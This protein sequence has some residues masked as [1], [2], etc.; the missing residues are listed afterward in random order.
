MDIKKTEE[1][2]RALYNAHGD[3]A[4]AEVAQKMRKCDEA[5][6]TDEAGDWKKIRE[7]IRAMRGANQ[8]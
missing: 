6:K 4:E 1:Y 2:A 3:K 8:G 7:A 5:G